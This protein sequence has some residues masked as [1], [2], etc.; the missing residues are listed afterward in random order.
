AIS[1]D[2]ATITPQAGFVLENTASM[3]LKAGVEVGG[4][5]ANTTFSVWYESGNLTG[6]PVLGTVNVTCKISI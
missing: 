4:A 3:K 2:P 5:V 1:V 6:T